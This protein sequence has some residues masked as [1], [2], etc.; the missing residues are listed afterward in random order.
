MSCPPPGDLPDPGVE[1]ASLMSPELG[2]GV[3]TTS[4][5]WE[6]SGEQPIAHV[7]LGSKG[8]PGSITFNLPVEGK[9][10]GNSMDRRDW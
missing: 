9:S 2:W 7:E 8:F 1:L 6:A 10:L 4:A 3:F 5:I